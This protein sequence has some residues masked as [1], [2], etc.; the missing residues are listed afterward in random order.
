MVL[1]EFDPEKKE[2]HL[3]KLTL[4]MRV[5]EFPSR[6][7]WASLLWHTMIGALD[8]NEMVSTE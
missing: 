3:G 7:K 4:F 2:H 8:K 1:G 6:I 5:R